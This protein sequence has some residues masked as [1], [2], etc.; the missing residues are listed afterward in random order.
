LLDARIAFAKAERDFIVSQF[1]LAKQAGSL[2][3]KSLK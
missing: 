2:S 3:I 1:E